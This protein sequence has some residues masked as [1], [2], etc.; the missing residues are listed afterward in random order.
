MAVKKMDPK[1]L[2]AKRRANKQMVLRALTDPKFRKQLQDAPHQVVGKRLSA[3]E[4]REIDLVLVTV[5]GIERQISGISLNL[6]CMAP[7]F[8]E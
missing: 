5:K 6:L 4:Q 7:P 8:R 3:V 1:R 2:R